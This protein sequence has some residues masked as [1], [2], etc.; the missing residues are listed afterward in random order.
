MLATLRGKL[1]TLRRTSAEKDTREEI[2]SNAQSDTVHKVDFDISPD[3]PLLMHMN[4][5]SGVVDID[6]LEVESPALEEMKAAGVKLIIPLVS[7]GELVG[8]LNLGPRRSE[9]DYTGEDRNFL[10]SLATS[11]P[12]MSGSLMSSR[13]K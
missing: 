5:A 12:L 8:L 2:S 1:N 9:Q 6:E 7:Q 4:N 10:N 11:S 13:T 3:D